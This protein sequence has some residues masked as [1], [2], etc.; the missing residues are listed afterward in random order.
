MSL[1]S[2]YKALVTKILT[3]ILA[4][5]ICEELQSFNDIT[6]AYMGDARTQL[7]SFAALHLTV[8]LCYISQGLSL[9]LGLSKSKA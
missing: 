1:L 3:V 4:G 6:K 5:S 7:I 8:F 9:G 2:D